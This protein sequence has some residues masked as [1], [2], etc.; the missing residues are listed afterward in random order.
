MFTIEADELSA[1]FR[2]GT[3]IL[4]TDLM[5]RVGMLQLTNDIGMG[6]LDMGWQISIFKI[7]EC[8]GARPLEKLADAISKAKTLLQSKA[9]VGEA[10][11]VHVWLWMQFAMEAKSPFLLL[12]GANFVENLAGELYYL[13]LEASRPIFV[14]LYALSPHSTA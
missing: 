12:T 6:L 1:K 7:H 8:E 2:E 9:R 4:I 11:T 13:D 3:T 14:S 10:L 5:Y